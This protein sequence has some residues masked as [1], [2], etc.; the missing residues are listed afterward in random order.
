MITWP[1][2]D[3]YADSMSERIINSIELKK[4]AQ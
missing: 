3:R 2:D 4:A 1:M